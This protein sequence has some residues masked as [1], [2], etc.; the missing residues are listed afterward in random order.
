MDNIS[1]AEQ[2]LKTNGVINSY[3]QSLAQV[4]H[5]KMDITAQTRHAFKKD[6]LSSNY[7]FAQKAAIFLL[8]LWVL[9]GFLDSY[10]EP[11]NTHVLVNLRFSFFLVML[12]LIGLT[13]IRSLRIYWHW[14][15]CGYVMV[16]GIGMVLM[17]AELSEASRY[18]YTQGLLVVI[19]YA[20][21]VSR[22]QL[23]PA[24]LAGLVITAAYAYMEFSSGVIPNM[25]IYANVFF[26]VVTNV[27]GV[28]ILS[29]S[30]VLQLNEYQLKLMSV[31]KARSLTDLNRI[32]ENL[33][34]TDG[35]TGLANR[36]QF[37]EYLQEM[38]SQENSHISLLLLDVD[39][40]KAYNDY[41]GHLQGDE[42]L[43]KIAHC[44][45]NNIPKDNNHLAAR[46]GGEEF[47]VL[48]RDYDLSK[49]L[50]VAQKLRKAMDDEALVHAN[51]PIGKTVSV[52]IGVGSIL[53][54]TH[55]GK[56]K[57]ISEADEQLYAAKNNGRNQ[58]RFSSDLS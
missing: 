31:Q 51:N 20:Y 36:R 49:A 26:Q 53:A 7:G 8:F 22:L 29:Y 6:Y 16:A 10:F 42:C 35:L 32:L 37:D 44:I 19:F 54:G 58:I 25:H 50:Q 5:K 28:F 15:M 30:G 45:E 9:F 55:N 1:A 17:V 43:K 18:I 33:A 27:F 52:S 57:L 23:L 14:I 41:Y 39:H 46:Y 12:F 11:A 48:L 21:V 56:E 3:S 24:A 13:Y 38:M 40:F 2:H 47:A 34:T 4:I